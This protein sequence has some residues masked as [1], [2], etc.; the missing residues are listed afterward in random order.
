MFRM[1]CRFNLF[2]LA[3]VTVPLA[4]ALQSGSA[5]AETAPAIRKP[6]TIN[7]LKRTP[8]DRSQNRPVTRSEFT[9]STSACIEHLHQRVPNRAELATREDF[10]ALIQRQ[11]ELNRELRSINDK[12][13][14]LFP[15][16]KETMP[17]RELPQ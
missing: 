5:A 16:L 17:R 8:D 6:P 7:C 2:R 11:V 3:T 9:G 15:E 10:E 12:F 13:D 4:I 14:Q 1:K